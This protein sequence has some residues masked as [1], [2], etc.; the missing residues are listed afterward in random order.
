M[1]LKENST[2]YVEDKIQVEMQIKKGIE[3]RHH[4]MM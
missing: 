3:L 1:S 4:A 2:T